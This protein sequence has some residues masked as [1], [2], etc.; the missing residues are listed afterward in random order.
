[1]P[2][3]ELVSDAVLSRPGVLTEADLFS[4]AL[5]RGD[6]TEALFRAGSDRSVVPATLDPLLPVS[7]L[8]GVVCMVALE[9]ELRDPVEA[10]EPLLAREPEPLASDSS[11]TRSMTLSFPTF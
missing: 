2:D 6:R 4:G 1:V 3:F 5:F 8:R 10:D 9:L 11:G 7:I